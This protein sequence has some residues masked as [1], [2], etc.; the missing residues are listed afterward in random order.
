[1]SQWIRDNDEDGFSLEPIMN[2]A[3]GLVGKLTYGDMTNAYDTVLGIVDEV[4]FSNTDAVKFLRIM[5]KYAID[6]PDLDMRHIATLAAYEYTAAWVS[7][8]IIAEK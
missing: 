6:Q 5:N 8:M 7:S 1:L 4:L 2:E 3:R